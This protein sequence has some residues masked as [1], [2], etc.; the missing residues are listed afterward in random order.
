MIHPDEYNHGGEIYDL[1]HLKPVEVNITLSAHGNNP[2]LAIVL[3]VRYSNHCYSEGEAAIAGQAHDFVDHNDW[4]RWFSV[5]RHKSSLMLSDLI[6]QIHTKKAHFTGKQNWLVIELQEE[7]DSVIIP[8]YLY[9]TIRKNKGKDV[10]NG[11]LLDVVSAYMKTKGDNSPHRRGSMDRTA[12]AMLARKTL[13]GDA[14]GQ[15]RRRRR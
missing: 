9:F 14:V 5:E 12:F 11:L 8:F 1:S 2:E 10:E 3:N 4:P 13:A 15:P 7:Q 6:Q